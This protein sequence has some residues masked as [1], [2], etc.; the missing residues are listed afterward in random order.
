MF[1]PNCGTQVPHAA[2]HCGS[3]G[4]SLSQLHGAPMASVPHSPVTPH[5]AAAPP[6]PM[7]SIQNHL[8]VSILSTLFC[9]LPLGIVAI[10][11]A[12][13]VDGHLRRGDVIGAQLAANSAKT[14]STIAIV[15][16]LLV[17]GANV[18]FTLVAMQ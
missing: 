1:C 10:V 13:K 3:C 6:P 9:C 7:G 11:Y 15:A 18:L 14:W 4:T 12:S 5:Y 17:I 16:G 2:A 8:V